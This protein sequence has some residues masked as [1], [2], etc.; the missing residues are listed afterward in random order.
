M[1]GSGFWLV[2]PVAVFGGF[3]VVVY[4]F[5]CLTV[6][7][8]DMLSCVSVTSWLCAAYCCWVLFV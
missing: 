7:C 4:L 1:I 3:M 6:L 5:V 2:L 8:F